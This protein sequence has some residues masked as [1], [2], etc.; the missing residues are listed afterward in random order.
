MKE[1]KNAKFYLF[2]ILVNFRIEEVDQQSKYIVMHMN[3]FAANHLGYKFRH[4][5]PLEIKSLITSQEWPYVEVRD[6]LKEGR[7]VFAKV[8]IDKIKV[9]CNYGGLIL[10]AE[11]VS[12]TLLNEP[13]KCDYLLEMTENITRQTVKFYKNHDVTTDNIIGKYI[14]HSKIHPNLKCRLFVTFKGVINVLFITI[15]NID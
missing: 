14:N 8:N 4:I 13:S 12:K 10:S 6:G 7:G 9:V 2:T 3:T 11:E 1:E 15:R 5:M